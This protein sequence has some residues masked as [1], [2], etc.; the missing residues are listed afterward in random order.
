MDVEGDEMN[1][2]D[3][4]EDYDRLARLCEAKDADYRELDR[5]YAD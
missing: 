3:K 5:H 4:M 2:L 1:S